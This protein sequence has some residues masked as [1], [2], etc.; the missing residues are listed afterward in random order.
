MG[1]SRFHFINFTLNKEL[2]QIYA[3]IFLKSLALSMIGVFVPIYLL[4]ELNYSFV[5]VLL[6]FITMILV[7]SVLSPISAKICARF[8]HKHTIL[9]TVPFFLL[10]YVFLYM[11]KAGYPLYPLALVLGIAESL[12]WMAF[13]AEFIRDTDDE[14]RG[15][16]IS[17]WYTISIILGV[18][19]PLFGGVIITL[20]GFNVLFAIV[21]V[22]LLISV[23]P[24]F[25]S[26]ENYGRT[27]F[28]LRDVFNRERLK[29]SI[30]FVS[31]GFRAVGSGF[32][33]PVFIFFLLREY[34]SLGAV[35]SFASLMTAF[36]TWLIGKEIDKHGGILVRFGTIIDSIVWLLRMFPSK[37]VHILFLTF[38]GDSAYDAVD[39]T[40]TT[41][42]YK[43]AS[44]VSDRLEYLVFRRIFTNLGRLLCFLV[45][46]IGTYFFSAG[47]EINA[48]KV[49][50]VATAIVVYFHWMV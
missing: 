46:L 34:I 8:G 35:I 10:F 21:G 9:F 42:T 48:L 28:S 20:F 31:Y 23:V 12:Y 44:L 5:S 36:S 43:K 32:M 6:F 24:L 39:M 2:T 45:V 50:F 49:G 29:E 30:A 33:W 4:K 25:L 18:V 16:E 19:G 17:I 37:F 41:R 38:L 13:H 3:S 40:F 11:W 26:G 22:L 1:N 15:E 7:W 27:I 47:F 14:H